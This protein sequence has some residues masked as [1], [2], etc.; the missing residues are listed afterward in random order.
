MK[1][2][3]MIVFMTITNTAFAQN[4]VFPRQEQKCIEVKQSCSFNPNSMCIK[5]YCGQSYNQ[6]TLDQFTQQNMVIGKKFN[7]PI[8]IEEYFKKNLPKDINWLPIRTL[9]QGVPQGEFESRRITII[10]TSNNIVISA[11]IG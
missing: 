2:K 6:Y 11:K 7:N 10:I 1:K 8:E 3:L 5:T 9:E 4:I